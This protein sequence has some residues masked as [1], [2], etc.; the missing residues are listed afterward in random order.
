MGGDH[1]AGMQLGLLHA[2]VAQANDPHGVEFT[3]GTVGRALV[4]ACL[5]AI[6]LGLSLWA[7]LDV[8]HR[9]RWAWALAER[10]QV[11]WLAAIMLGVFSVVG[12]VVISGWY[13]L[14]VRPVIADAEAGH[15]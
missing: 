3:V 8:A 2:V 15:L 11:V 14:R 4:L 7:L 9:P 6:P 5:A 12:G 1:T 10:R 13:L